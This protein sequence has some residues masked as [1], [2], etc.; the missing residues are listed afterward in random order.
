MGGEKKGRQR[1]PDMYDGCVLVEDRGHQSN[2]KLAIF[3]IFDF[4]G[5]EI[6][7]GGCLK[8]R[9]GFTRPQLY[10]PA[11]HTP[12]ELLVVLA[13]THSEWTWPVLVISRESPPSSS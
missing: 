8:K 2:R 3:H 6:W 12:G 7:P 1:R 9:P 13:Q 4:L 10:S 5:Y 11:F